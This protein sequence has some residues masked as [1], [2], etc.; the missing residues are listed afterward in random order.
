MLQK[1]G[2]VP[3]GATGAECGRM[4]FDADEITGFIADSETAI[5]L[6][7]VPEYI[8]ASKRQ[9]LEVDGQIYYVA[10]STVQLA[11]KTMDEYEFVSQNVESTSVNF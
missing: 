5:P 9:V 7:E 8:G 3:E 6:L 10:G 2:R 4:R 1:M 11:A